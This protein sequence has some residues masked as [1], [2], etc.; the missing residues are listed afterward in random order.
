[1]IRVLLIEDH[2]AVRDGLRP[3]INQQPDMEVV[4]E[5]EDGQFGLA[6]PAT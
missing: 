3:L 5:A 2:A 6:L 4:A 1:M